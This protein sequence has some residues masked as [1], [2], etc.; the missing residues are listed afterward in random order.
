VGSVE[1]G[2]AAVGSAAA[3]GSAEEVMAAVDS[4]AAA[5]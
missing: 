2:S 5:G 4:A 3:A 1:E